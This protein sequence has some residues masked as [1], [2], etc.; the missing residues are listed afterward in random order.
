MSGFDRVRS[1]FASPRRAVAVAGLCV[2][3]VTASGCGSQGIYSLPLPGGPNTGS[4][5][6]TLTADFSDV[7]DLVPQSLVKVNGVP[8][9]KVESI[10][11]APDGW[12]A[13]VKMTL[14]NDVDLPEN[15]TAAV[16]MTNLLG[17]KYVELDPPTSAPATTKLASGD[18]IP[19]TR[20]GR[21]VQ[22]EEVLGAMSLLLN[23]GGFAQVQPIVQELNKALGGREATVRSLLERTDKLIDGI[24]QQRD[25][26][27]KAL[28]GLGVLT[29]TVNGQRDEIGKA[30]DELPKGI[31]VLNEQEPQFI[32]MLKQL[33]RLGQVGTDVI[34]KSRDNL[35]ADLRALRP[36]VQALAASAPDLIAAAPVLPTFP[37]PDEILPAIHGGSANVFLS[38]DTRIGQLLSNLG[39]GERN[40]VYVKPYGPHQVPVDPTNPYINGN[41]PRGGWPTVSLLPPPQNAAPPAPLQARPAKGKPGDK[42][43]LPNPFALIPAP[44]AV[45]GSHR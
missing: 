36:T 38:I 16:K 2:V 41:G 30:L 19:L 35:I 21:S 27:T 24:N 25:D 32:A 6:M 11:L 37:I 40:P 14:R 43:V 5:P 3:A 34:T 44:P 23:G 31:A 7:L 26:I 8:V 22:L 13:R 18:M 1:V 33:D 29:N 10:D 28:D 45:G 17:E 12:S 20:T 9:G 15:S 4:N 42:P 39:V